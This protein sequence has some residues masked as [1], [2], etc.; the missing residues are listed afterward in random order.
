LIGH[1]PTRLGCV[2]ERIVVVV[3]AR[4]SK[5]KVDDYTRVN[6]FDRNGRSS[7]DGSVRGNSWRKVVCSWGGCGS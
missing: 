1:E 2:G 3:L 6:V 5:G 7:G 4:R